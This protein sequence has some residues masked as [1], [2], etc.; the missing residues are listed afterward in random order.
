MGRGTFDWAIAITVLVLASPYPSPGQHSAA[1]KAHTFRTI[2]GLFT[3]GYEQAFNEHV[4]VE[5][6]L[7]G[8]HYIDVRP[9]RFED[10]KVTGIGAIGA[11]RY[12][13]FTN[14]AAAPRGFFGYGALRYIDFRE[15]FLN[16]ASGDHYKVGGNMINV[17][18]GVGYKFVY[19][20]VGLEAFIGWGAGRLKS[21]DGESR[22]QIPVFYRQGIEEQEHFPQLDVAICY[23]FSPFSND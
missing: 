13:P 9:N 11:L 8:G 16:T 4:S 18:L 1:L 21:D 5:F 3:L 10:Y 23:M 15:A 22:N 2:D 20:R 19:H 7:Q 17:G 14:K 12:Y 6:S